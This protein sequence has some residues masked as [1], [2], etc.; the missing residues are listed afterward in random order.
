MPCAGSL[1]K[2][3]SRGPN[4][5]LWSGSVDLDSLCAV[6]SHRVRECARSR[7]FARSRENL[8]H[9]TPASCSIRLV[10]KASPRTARSPGTCPMRLAEAGSK[11]P[12]LHAFATWSFNPS[13]R[14]ASFKTLNSVSEFAL[15]GFMSAPITTSAVASVDSIGRRADAYWQLGSSSCCAGKRSRS[16]RCSQRGH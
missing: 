6:S 7:A 15:S 10:K 3:R 9:H 8:A 13:V 12:S 11:S 4:L 16:H 5:L 1:G 2:R 14:A